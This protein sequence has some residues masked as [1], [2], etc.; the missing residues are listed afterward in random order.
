L[1]GQAHH[2]LTCLL[3]LHACVHVVL[4]HPPPPLPASL[5]RIKEL[6]EKE[7]DVDKKMGLRK[8]LRSLQG[9]SMST[10]LPVVR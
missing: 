6:S 7:G 4:K 1:I 10:T 9:V 2:S 8:L 5:P 3:D